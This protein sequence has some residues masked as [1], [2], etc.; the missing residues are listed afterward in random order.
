[1]QFQQQI[2]GFPPA[3]GKDFDPIP[4][5]GSLDSGNDAIPVA[6]FYD[7]SFGG[8]II[9]GG[10]IIGSEMG[11]N[12]KTI[13]GMSIY[14]QDK[15]GTAT[16][17]SMINQYIKMAHCTDTIFPSGSQDPTGATASAVSL[18]N[19]LTLT[20]ETTVYSG[21]LTFDGAT[22]VW[23][24]KI[25]FDTPFEYNGRD[26][27]AMLWINADNSYSSTRYE[28]GVVGGTARMLHQ[29]SDTIAVENMTAFRTDQIPQ[30][31]FYY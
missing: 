23:T 12:R 21:S 29:E 11:T 18:S 13:T 15:S 20:D 30:T 19:I 6:Q 5:S 16:S 9:L 26:N 2:M 3:R 7:Q 31:K 4:H 27:V 17:V 25:T 28:W 1:M 22:G 24:D 8:W 14:K 10:D